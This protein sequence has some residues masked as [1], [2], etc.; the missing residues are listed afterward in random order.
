MV[1]SLLL[2]LAVTFPLIHYISAARWPSSSFWTHE[3]L[4]HCR[5][6]ANADLALIYLMRLLFILLFLI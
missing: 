6:L 4:Y 3:A 1:H 2:F 5:V